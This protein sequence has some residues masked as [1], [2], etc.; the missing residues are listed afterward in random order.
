MRYGI[1]FLARFLAVLAMTVSALAQIPSLRLPETVEAGKAFTANTSGS[2]AAVLYIAGP[3]D[4]LRRNVRLGETI[5]FGAEDLRNAGH[6]LAFLVVGS[7]TQTSSFEVTPSHQ[8]A[9]LSFFAKPSRLPVNRPDGISGVV[10]V[11]DAF[12]NLVLELRQ[13]SFALS[14]ATGA[15]QARDET[16]RNGLAWVKIN[17][18][19]RA[20]PAEFKARVG[21]VQVRRVVQQVAGDPCAVRIRARQSGPRILLETDPV[22][23]CSG[24]PVPDGTIVSFTETYADGQATVDAP[25]KRGVARTEMPA[26]RGAVISA[27]VGVVMGNEIRWNGG[28]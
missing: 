19:A 24:N 15:T 25:L 8:P 14:G 6:Y 2:G 27:A 16:T 3:G 4:V 22:H 7:L 17:S 5:S 9:A 28:Q 18:A 12:H 10:Y 1:A 11:F 21:S 20:G 13:V 26:R 23:D